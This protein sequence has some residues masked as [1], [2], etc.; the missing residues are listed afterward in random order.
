MLRIAHFILCPKAKVDCVLSHVD[1]F[2]VVVIS[3]ITHYVYEKL[4][5]AMKKKNYVYKFDPVVIKNSSSFD[6]IFSKNALENYA[7]RT[8]KNTKEQKGWSMVKINLPFPLTIVTCT[9]EDESVPCRRIQM[10][11]LA[12]EFG[13]FEPFI[14]LSNT[15][16]MKYQEK[17]E[18]YFNDK[19][20]DAWK[21]K[22]NAKNYVTLNGNN[23]L[24]PI[25][26]YDRPNRILY[27]GTEC[28]SF[29]TIALDC[30]SHYATTASFQEGEKKLEVVENE[31][32][33]VRDEVVVFVEGHND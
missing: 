7:F 14:I 16:I 20:L 24:A 25:D 27:G 13:D 19:F 23:K 26:C 32:I 12:R 6:L 10:G 31:K 5:I 3:N 33:D 17:D 2:E 30:T 22:G 18:S 8:F 15:N 11:Q 1:E 21:E 4:I 9:L 29:D 28:L